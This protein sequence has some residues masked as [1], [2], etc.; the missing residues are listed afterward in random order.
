M[1]LKYNDRQSQNIN[2][3]KPIEIVSIPVTLKSE[4]HIVHLRRPYEILKKN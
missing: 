2:L 3:L 1:F 4:N